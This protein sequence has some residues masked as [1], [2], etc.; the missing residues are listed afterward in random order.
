M[1]DQFTTQ[2]V[3]VDFTI[4]SESANVIN[5][6]LQ[7]KGPSGREIQQRAAVTMYLSDDANGDS[8]SSAPD[9][10][11]IGTDGVIIDAYAASTAFT[12]VSESDGDIDIDITEATG[13]DEFFLVVILPNGELRVSDA[14]TFAA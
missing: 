12:V 5:V 1:S 7:L 6:A 14:I 3:D 11:A 9:S 4:G 8:I 2:V 10:V 13:A